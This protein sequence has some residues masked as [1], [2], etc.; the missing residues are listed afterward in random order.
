MITTHT[1][2]TILII[3]KGS[4]ESCGMRYLLLVTLIHM[5]GWVQDDTLLDVVGTK[6]GSSSVKIK[7]GVST[8]VLSKS[9]HTHGGGNNIL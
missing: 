4:S 5:Q 3:K 2:T 1:H 9:N 8:N 7:D 6:S